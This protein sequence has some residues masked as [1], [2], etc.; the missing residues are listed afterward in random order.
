[1]ANERK[2]RGRE[3]RQ[4]T[5]R[6]RA[7]THQGGGF[8]RT[9]F[10]VPKGISVWKPKAG[11]TYTVDILPFK[12]SKRKFM[13]SITFADPGFEH[14]ERTF[15]THPRIG[16]NENAYVCS[17]ATFDKPCFPCEYRMKLAKKDGA[18]EQEIKALYAKERQLFCVWDHADKS[19][20][21]QL[22]E[23]SFHLFGKLLDTRIKSAKNGR[24]DGFYF[25]DAEGKTLE[26]TFVEKQMGTNK[27]S[28]VVSIDFMDRD[29]EIPEEVLAKVP[30]L[31]DLIIE[32]PYDR[33]KKIFLQEP[34]AEDGAG[35]DG[36]APDEDDDK[37]VKK[38]PAKKKPPVDDDDD[39]TENEDDDVK[40]T[41]KKKPAKDDDDDL[42]DDPKPAKK[43]AKAAIEDDD[44]VKP[45]KKKPPVDDDD[46]TK[47]AKKKEP[48]ADE[49][50]LEVGME[51][52]YKGLD[53]VIQKI[54]GDGTSLALKDEDDA[55][56]KAIGPDE[57]RIPKPAAKKKPP[58]DDDD[59][60]PKPV[61]K[62]KPAEEDDDDLL[63]DD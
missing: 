28:E 59:D 17:A 47:P 53:C 20:G 51:V 39:L 45:V 12:A 42:D 16:P 27:F 60:D 33:L 18:A 62:K 36:G 29:E 2:N 6:R 11:E 19:K 9:T 5:A 1:M 57:V 4:S 13:Q 43:T 49:L 44:D 31:D 37:P 40:P 23:V 35:D 26:L 58:V 15:F 21:P 61:K 38:K 32:T 56:H 34:D 22:W 3:E 14:Y 8:A 41:A 25:P 63:D 7:E 24:Y 55:I 54:S 52:T 30:C 50:G 46:D 10:K 48:T